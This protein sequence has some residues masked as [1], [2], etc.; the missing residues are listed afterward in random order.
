MNPDKAAAYFY[1][2]GR[3]EAVDS[4]VKKMKNVDMGEQ[5][6]PQ[7]F[8]NTGFKVSA[9]SSDSSEFKIRSKK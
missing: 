5:T 9:I 4:T 1:E 8:G 2:L 6:V 3:S 7:S